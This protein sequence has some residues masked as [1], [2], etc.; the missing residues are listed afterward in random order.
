MFKVKATLVEFLGDE[1]I[2]PCHFSHKIGDE[3]IYDGER[4][5]GRICPHT[6]PMLMPHLYALYQAGP[7]YVQ[8]S[9]YAPFWYVPQTVRDESM[10]HLDGVGWKCRKEPYP[11]PRYSMGDLTPKGGFA[12]PTL[13]E[14]TVVKDAAF[15]CPDSRTSAVFVLEAIDINDR[16]DSAPY[17]RL[18]MI[19]LSVARR[20][21]G[22]RV[23]DMRDR[24]SRERREEIYPLAAPVL[25]RALVEEL[26]SMH[27]VETRNDQV[28]VTEKGERKMADFLAT[29]PEKD[30]RALELEQL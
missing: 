19:L 8:P 24:L 16:G 2:F 10:K 1:K 9:Y 15:V 11:E 20:N 4:F 25:V 27:Y 28:F 14:R 22:I 21:P 30:R 17:F 13:S 12:Y 23:D 18:Q 26:E 5:H 3:L 29:L 6:F 7:R